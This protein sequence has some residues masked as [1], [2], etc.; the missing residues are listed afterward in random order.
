LPHKFN[1]SWHV[2]YSDE[3]AK[4]FRK[5]LIAWGK[6][7]CREFPWRNTDNAYHILL[8]EMMLRRTNAPQVVPVYIDFIRRYPTAKLLVSASRND[9]Y[10]ALQPLG[11]AWRAENIRHMA[12]VLVNQFDGHVPADYEKLKMLP[13]VGDY[14]ASAVCSFAFNRPMPV[15]DTNTVRVAGRYFG[16]PTHAE[17]RR[18]KAVRQT[19]TAITSNRNAR[20]FNFYFLD[21]ASIICKANNPECHICPVN[22]RCN[23]GQKRLRG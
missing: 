1:V 11:L 12:E 10:R 16:F 22:K 23:Y 5:R 13:G 6:L 9:V 2:S 17:S 8:A 14:V 18:I 19:V 20:D 3:K 7:N 4:Y 15:I 21:F